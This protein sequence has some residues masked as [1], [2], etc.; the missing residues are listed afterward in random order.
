MKPEIKLVPGQ[1]IVITP[2]EGVFKYVLMV[3]QGK[4]IL[5]SSQEV[6]TKTNADGTTID[7]DK[8][9]W[10][11]KPTAQ[12]K[13]ITLSVWTVDKDGKEGE[14]AELN[15]IEQ[16]DNPTEVPA[17]KKNKKSEDRKSIPLWMLIAGGA[18]LA[19][20]FTL[21]MLSLKAKKDAISSLPSAVA[22]AATNENSNASSNAVAP[23]VGTSFEK[24]GV[25]YEIIAHTNKLAFTN[26]TPVIE[27]GVTIGVNTVIITNS[28]VTYSTNKST[29]TKAP[30][31]AAVAPPPAPAGKHNSKPASCGE[32]QVIYADNNNG[33]VIGH[34]DN[35]VIN[36]Y[37]NTNSLVMVGGK[38]LKCSNPAPKKLEKNN[39]KVYR[40]P[41]D[42]GPNQPC[43][44]FVLGPD[45][46][47]VF[48]KLPGW[49]FKANFGK[50]GAN[51]VARGTK[52]NGDNVAIAPG[53]CL[54]QYKEVSFYSNDAEPVTFDV[55]L[56]R[57]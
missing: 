7:F 16:L 6:F 55:I 27:N 52:H 30:A 51:I 42:F 18:L 31:P 36:N 34:L 1:G 2:V 14:I 21:F 33:V 49:S 44:S 26:I 22:I 50:H 38:E 25:Q 8:I 40:I 32:N 17:E 3:V 20:M 35:L 10:K 15:N 39:F 11:A 45:Q 29:V 13:N 5:A 54:K 57:P 28:V 43:A 23:A 56:V 41:E 47:I 46:T 37:G 12:T 4:N 9:C 24:D 48:Q 53:E 19:A